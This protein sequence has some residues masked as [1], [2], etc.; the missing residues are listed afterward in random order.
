MPA[1]FIIAVGFVDC[2][3]RYLS[4][5]FLTVAL[6]CTAFGRS[7]Y[8]INHVDIAPRFAGVLFGLTNT[9]ATIPGMISPYIAAAITPNVREQYCCQKVIFALKE[10]TNFSLLSSEIWCRR[11]MSV[12][13]CVAGNGG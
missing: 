11:Y 4:V 13:V 2:A 9:V 12:S 6:G 10:Y 7:A 1:I 3:H 5:V 8:S